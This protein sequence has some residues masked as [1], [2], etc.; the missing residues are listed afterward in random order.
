ME[1]YERL[2]K[3]LPVVKRR[4]GRQPKLLWFKRYDPEGYAAALKFVEM[5]AYDYVVFEAM[6]VHAATFYRWMEK[7]ENNE[8]Q[9]Y[10]EFYDDIVRARAKARVMAEINVRQD[11]PEFWLR[12]GP[13]RT[14][15]GREGWTD[16]REID[17]RLNGEPTGKVVL[18]DPISQE[19]LEETIKTVQSIGFLRG[20]DKGESVSDNGDGKLHESNGEENDDDT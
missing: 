18:D 5:G 17:I 9:I 19:E 7:G 6:G 8:S 13:G 1:D 11:K 12:S 4:V 3:P 16:S 20:I 2:G 10:R 15:P 14:R